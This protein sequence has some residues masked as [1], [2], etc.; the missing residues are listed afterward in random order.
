MCSSGR[1]QKG[2]SPPPGASR[3]P[4]SATQDSCSRTR[5]LFTHVTLPSTTTILLALHHQLVRDEQLVLARV[6]ADDQREAALLE[7]A[8]VGAE[9][10]LESVRRAARTG[11]ARHAQSEMCASSKTQGRGAAAGRAVRQDHG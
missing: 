7:H 9:R 5:N 4:L 1:A 6:L 2:G 8:E 11:Q 3:A 10:L